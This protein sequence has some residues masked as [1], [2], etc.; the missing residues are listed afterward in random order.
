MSDSLIL[1]NM[2]LVPAE[3]IDQHR[4]I[5]STFA[6]AIVQARRIRPDTENGVGGTYIPAADALKWLL[7][8]DA[9]V[10]LQQ[11]QAGEVVPRTLQK[12][13]YKELYRAIV[14]AAKQSE[15]GKAWIQ[16]SKDFA[17]LD[18]LVRE[19]DVYFHASTAVTV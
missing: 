17:E 18:T 19:A 9:F 7:S 8:A 14:D 6:Q 15:G 13:R 11:I 16:S 4:Q 1:S 10:W 2:N 3:K 12:I 5:W